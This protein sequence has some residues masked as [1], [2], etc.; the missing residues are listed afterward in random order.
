MKQKERIDQ[1][2]LRDYALIADGERG[3]IVGPS[4]NIA[5]MCFPQWDNPAIFSHLLGGRGNFAIGPTETFVWGGFYE[6][7]SLIWHSRWVT[8]NGIAESRDA[9]AFPGSKTHARILRR[10]HGIEGDVEI[11]I[12]I[13]PRNDYGRKGVRDW[14]R[15]DDGRWHGRCD[16]AY[17][18]VTGIPNG[19][20]DN[21]RG[22]L[23]LRMTVKA[24]AAHDVMMEMSTSP[25]EATPPSIEN[26]WSGTEAAWKRNVPHFQH[27]PG[28]R[29]VRQSYAVLRG[30]TSASG[31]MVAAATTSLPERADKGRSY[32]YR[33]AWLR[34]QAI[35][36][37]ALAAAQ[38]EELVRSTVSFVAARLLEDG[39]SVQPAYTV[40]G[41]SIP[42][43]STIPVAGYPGGNDRIGN[44]VNAQFQLDVFG[45]ALLLFA[46]AARLDLLDA[47]GWRA[48]TIARDAIAQRWKEPDNGV[49]ELGKRHWT[50]SKLVCA[51]GL[52]AIAGLHEQAAESSEWLSLSDM[53]V[54]ETDRTGLHKS[55]RWQRAADDDRIDAA[56]LVPA[57]RGAVPHDDPR[58]LATMQAVEQDLSTD[59]YVYRYRPDARPLGEAEG[60]FGLCGFWLAQA[61]W[62]CGDRVG[63]ARLFERNRSAAGPP[64]LLSEEFDIQERQ[65]RGNLPQAFVHAALIE[66]AVMQSR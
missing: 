35:T 57:L 29:D 34:D 9:L 47:D 1:H 18:R 23:L 13:D 48:V 42:D 31:A 30:L 46:A 7:G 40:N 64:G 14:N 61:K 15:D 27:V 51:A 38:S 66:T 52:R 60:A 39:A 22:C 21:E 26:L 32:D 65:M 44:H 20:I 54:A 3:A 19:H 63:A 53:I 17:V 8:T 4:G 49:W 62:Q 6:E 55:G 56:L 24:G 59:G 25:F 37:Q 16:D 5:W 43:E 12:A 10:I 11:E 50:H 2:V 36:G 33:Y 45:E 28:E 41:T 58:S